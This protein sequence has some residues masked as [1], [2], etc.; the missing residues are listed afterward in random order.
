MSKIENGYKNKMEI[1]LFPDTELVSLFNRKVKK[2]LNLDSKIIEFGC[3][4]GNN[5]RMLVEYE[6]SNISG[7][8]ISETAVNIGKDMILNKYKKNINLFQ[9]DFN[10][11]S[12]EDKYDLIIDRA[13]ITHVRELN[14]DSFKKIHDLLNDN[15]VL[16][17]CCFFEKSDYNPNPEMYDCVNYF[18]I[19]KK[20]IEEYFDIEF[21][22]EINKNMNNQINIKYYNFVATKKLLLFK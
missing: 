17:S 9:S 15:G 8:D 20:T 4:C 2:N 13:C 21:L 16:L 10:T 12:S 6:F 3:G 11:F 1:N 5:I 22:E 18:S 14:K 19:F 7:F